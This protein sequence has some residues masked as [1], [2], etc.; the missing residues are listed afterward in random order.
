MA[1]ARKVLLFVFLG[2]PLLA[3]LL[4]T[5]VRMAR[6]FHKFPMPQFIAGAIDNSLRRRIQL[7]DDIPT[8]E[9]RRVNRRRRGPGRIPKYESH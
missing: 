7:D 8:P 3:L 9:T 1:T 4:H 5:L 6:A 2:L